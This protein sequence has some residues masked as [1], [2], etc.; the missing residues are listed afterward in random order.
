V[1]VTF[2]FGA[3]FHIYLKVPWNLLVHLDSPYCRKAVLKL[4]SWLLIN[5]SESTHKKV[6]LCHPYL[7]LK[8]FSSYF[9]PHLYNEMFNCGYN[10]VIYFLLRVQ[11]KRRDTG[12][13]LV[14]QQHPVLPFTISSAI[15]SCS[16]SY[17]IYLLWWKSSKVENDSFIPFS[18]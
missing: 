16:P 12:C 14:N 5:T 1:T 4:V 15:K 7:L 18:Y 9:H 8:F 6:V 3:L 10:T 13:K 2:S 17:V 11:Y